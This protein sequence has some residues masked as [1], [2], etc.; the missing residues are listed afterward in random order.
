MGRSEAIEEKQGDDGIVVIAGRCGGEQ[1]GL[2]EADAGA[3]GGGKARGG[4]GKHGGA[5]IE[6]VD[7]GVR[8]DG[9]ETNEAAAVAFAEHED[10]PAVGEAGQKM[11]ARALQIAAESEEL[12]RAVEG[13][14][15]IETFDGMGH[16]RK[17]RGV[18]FKR[19]GRKA[20]RG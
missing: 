4:A 18:C 14:E 7:L 15:T 6:T 20:R 10:A 9:E 13:G 19:R 8:R 1:V 12:K 3:V 16:A 5:E 17:R 11:E 2:L